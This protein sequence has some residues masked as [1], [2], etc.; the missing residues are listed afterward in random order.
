MNVISPSGDF[1][2]F[3]NGGLIDKQA[4]HDL[5]KRMPVSSSL[6]KS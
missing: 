5:F 4:Q 2:S 6:I 1:L 3:Y